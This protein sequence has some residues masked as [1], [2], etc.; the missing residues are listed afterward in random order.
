MEGISPF[1]LGYKN[2]FPS[3]EKLNTQRSLNMF[4]LQY[5]NKKVCLKV[6][7][8]NEIMESPFKFEE[9]MGK[10][11]LGLESLMGRH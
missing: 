5:K 11:N 10:L 3:K 6:Y 2:C 8:S 4:F 9:W 7:P 1:I